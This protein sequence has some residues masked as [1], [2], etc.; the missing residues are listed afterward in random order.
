MDKIEKILEK[1][2]RIRTWGVGIFVSILAA[3]ILRHEEEI[4]IVIV[5]ISHS[6]EEILYES[7]KI[8]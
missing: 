1:I 2:L 8:I 4:L 7:K 5:K 3:P 6:K